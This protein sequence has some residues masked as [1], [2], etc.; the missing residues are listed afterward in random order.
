MRDGGRRCAEGSDTTRYRK[1]CAFT[2]WPPYKMR[3]FLG[4][5][6]TSSG[7]F[8]SNVFLK[9]QF[10]PSEI[11]YVHIWIL[12]RSWKSSHPFH[13]V[14]PLSPPDLPPS[15]QICLSILSLTPVSK[16]RRKPQ[17]VPALLHQA[18][19]RLFLAKF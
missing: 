12:C 11:I 19:F 1:D 7:N 16:L 9:L 3:N 2:L 13:S 17:N 10:H 5:Q 15:L 6:N 18:L 8:G 4:H 14:F